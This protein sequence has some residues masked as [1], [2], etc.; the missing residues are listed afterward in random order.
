M[1]S[2]SSRFLPASIRTAVYDGY[3]DAAELY[4]ALQRQLTGKPMFPLLQG[5]KIGR[6]WV[7]MLAHPGEAK[8]KSLETLPVAVDV[9]VRKVTEYLGV[10]DTYGQDLEQVR[11]L[12]Q[13]AWSRNVYHDGALGPAPL[14]DTPSALD[15]ALW[16]FAKWGCTY[17]ERWGRK[18]PISE[19]CSGCRF[20]ELR[21]PP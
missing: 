15:P 17:C 2:L 18:V 10:T 12:I 8:I 21:R 9:Q 13:T 3:G 4:D 7:R 5:P 1:E 16:F 19:I 11:A 6:M 20:E 14:A